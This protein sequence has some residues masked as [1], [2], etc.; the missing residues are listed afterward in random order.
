MTKYK[1]E[2]FETFENY[3]KRIGS[4]DM[5]ESLGAYTESLDWL[6]ANKLGQDF[7]NEIDCRFEKEMEVLKV[8]DDTDLEGLLKQSNDVELEKMC[9]NARLPGRGT[10]REK[11]ERLLDWR[12]K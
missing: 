4:P 6:K 3:L 9:L 7:Q 5:E 11:A 8:L 10:I 2:L 12:D 1:E